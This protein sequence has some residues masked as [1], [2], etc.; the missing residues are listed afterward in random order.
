MKTLA[1]HQGHQNLRAGTQD[2]QAQ[3]DNIKPKEAQYEL[4][5]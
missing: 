2:S 3:Q 5:T 4:K 1:K